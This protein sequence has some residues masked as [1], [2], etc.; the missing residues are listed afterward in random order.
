MS[1]YR[2]EELQILGQNWAHV[3]CPYAKNCYSGETCRKR[4]AKT[5][6]SL[7]IKLPEKYVVDQPPEAFIT[8]DKTAFTNWYIGLEGT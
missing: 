3:L 4:G 5:Q 1:L 6:R 8:V 2:N 7:Q